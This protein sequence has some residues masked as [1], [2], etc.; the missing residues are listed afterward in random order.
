[1]DITARITRDG[2][3]WTIEVPEVP[4]AFARASDRSEVTAVAADAAAAVLGVDPASISVNVEEMPSTGG[5]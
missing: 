1:M 2:S 3:W 5:W 4:G